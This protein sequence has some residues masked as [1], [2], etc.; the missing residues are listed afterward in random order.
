MVPLIFFLGIYCEDFL[1]KIG[2][3]VEVD[4]NFDFVMTFLFTFVSAEVLERCCCPLIRYES[5]N[6]L[7]PFY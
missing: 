4:G 7:D 6:G 2:V 5:S 3:P 1:T